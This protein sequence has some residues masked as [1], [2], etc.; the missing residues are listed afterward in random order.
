METTIFCRLHGSDGNYYLGFRV[1]GS[2]V[3][4]PCLRHYAVLLLLLLLVDVHIHFFVI[5]HLCIRPCHVPTGMGNQKGSAAHVLESLP[6]LQFVP[7][8]AKRRTFKQAALNHF[9][10]TC[11]SC[12]PDSEYPPRSFQGHPAFSTK[13][14][15]SHAP[16]SWNLSQ[17]PANCFF[18]L[19]F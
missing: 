2:I 3:N 1:L 4:L 13:T 10:R 19:S 14:S 9:I 8:L 15:T 18:C 7:I 6:V 11:V 16:R 12:F 5:F 17:N